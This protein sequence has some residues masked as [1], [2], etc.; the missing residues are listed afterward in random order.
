MMADRHHSWKSRMEGVAEVPKRL[1]YTRKSTEGEDRQASSHERQNEDLDRKWGP[2]DA[3]WVWR[4]SHTGTTFDRPE[5]QDL[6]DFCRAHPHRKNDP[7]YIEMV[8]PSRFGR[9]LDEEG[10]PD[11]NAYMILYLE[12]ERLGWQLRF[13]TLQLTGNPM[14]DYALIAIHAN[15]ASTYSA[16]NSYNASSGKRKHS[17]DGWWVHAIPPYGTRRLD[18]RTG[19]VLE[20][21]EASSAGGGGVVLVLDQKTHEH[22]VHGVQRLLDGISY[23]AIG[24]EL[25]DRGARGRHGGKLGHRH[26]KQILANRAL[27]GEVQVTETDEDGRKSKRWVKAKWGPLVDVKLFR[28]AEAE[29]ERR[30]GSPRNQKRKVRASYPLRPVCA[31]CGTEYNGGR[32][33]KRQGGGRCYIHPKPKKRQDPELYRLFEERGCLVYTVIADELESAIKDLIV[34]ERASPEFEREVRDLILERDEFRKDAATAVAAHR[35][36]LDEAKKR[37]LRMVRAVAIVADGDFDEEVFKKETESVKLEVKAAE[38]RLQEAEELATSRHD[39]WARL[40]GIIDETR[41]LAAAWERG[42]AEQ[43]KAL[44]DY[45]VLDVWIAVEP[46]PG[47]KRANNKTAIVTLQTTPTNLRHFP[48][49]RQHDSAS[50]IS[51]RTQSSSSTKKRRRSSSATRVAD[52]SGHSLEETIRPSAQAACPRTSGSSSSSEAESTGIASGDPQLPSAT[53]TL[54]SSPRRLARLTGD[55]LNR[56]ENSS[57]DS[58]ISSTSSAPCTPERAQNAGSSVTRENLRLNGH[59]SWQMSQP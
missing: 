19:K 30:S 12:L 5:F 24:A 23:D 39:A 21:G 7:G 3:R 50:E 58:D 27:I 45:W 36:D 52:A 59:T 42:G 33:S 11:V 18:T 34:K 4:D 46:I 54:R 20:Q 10:R 41:N 28:A 40:S 17:A 53:A 29:I 8:A 22:W 43:R 57:C 47:K 13:V 25:Y 1:R 48:I 35:R 15:E 2:V 44:L 56:R 6:I 37:L 38:R 32:L 16:N 51:S 49:G 55:A 14:V 26:V 9:I 31:H